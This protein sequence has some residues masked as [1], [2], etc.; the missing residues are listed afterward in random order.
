MTT[1]VRNG[2]VAMQAVEDVRLVT[3]EEFVTDLVCQ[4]KLSHVEEVKLADTFEDKRFARAYEML[5][6]N[7]DRF[8]LAVDFSLATNPYHGDSST[9][10][11]AIYALR[12]RRIVA[13]NNPRLKTVEFKVDEDD[14]N[15]YLDHSS[16]PRS[17]M[18]QIVEET[19]GAGTARDDK[20]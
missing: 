5:V 16:I 1:V 8:G 9:L 12:D 2:G 17:L 15:Y 6:E 11:E 3:S 19:F 14:A 4:L 7:Q 20:R 13:I 10:R 18:A